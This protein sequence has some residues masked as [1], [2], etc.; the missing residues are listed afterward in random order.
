MCVVKG[1]EEL[2]NEFDQSGSAAGYLAYI[3][4]IL[5]FG[6]VYT[7]EKLGSSTVWSTGMRLI[8]ADYAYV[9]STTA[10]HPSVATWLIDL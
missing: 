1:V 4:A 8:L 10:K 2:V 5:Y 6:T 7:L 9:V 3:I